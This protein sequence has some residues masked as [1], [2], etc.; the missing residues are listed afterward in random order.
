MHFLSSSGARGDLTVSGWPGTHN[1]PWVCTGGG[2]PGRQ[3]SPRG[4]REKPAAALGAPRAGLAPCS[5]EL[6]PLALRTSPQKVTTLGSL[7]Q[8]LQ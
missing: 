6:L 3:P 1:L 5:A 8:E 4:A 2:P 7:D